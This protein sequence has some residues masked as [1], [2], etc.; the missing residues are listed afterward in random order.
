MEATEAP[1]AGEGVAWEAVLAVWAID[2]VTMEGVLMVA[3]EVVEVATKEVVRWAAAQ[4]AAQTGPVV[5]VGFWEAV[6][7][8]L[9][10]VVAAVVSVVGSMGEALMATGGGRVVRAVEPMTPRAFAVSEPRR[11]M[12]MAAA[13]VAARVSVAMEK[14]GARDE[15]CVAVAMVAARAVAM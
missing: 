11:A 13:M 9:E 14:T 1:E 3:A 7:V 4:A 8:I 2:E 12:R 5:S 15:R 10:G 6:A